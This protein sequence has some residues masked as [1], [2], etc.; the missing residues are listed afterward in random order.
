MTFN[1]LQVAWLAVALVAAHST[2]AQAQGNEVKAISD[3]E[4]TLLHKQLVPAEAAW[5]SIPWQTSLLA[6]QNMAVRDQK[7]IFIWSMDGHPL[8]CT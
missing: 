3:S 2:W 6:A 7:P 4:F 1:R 5:S 8:G